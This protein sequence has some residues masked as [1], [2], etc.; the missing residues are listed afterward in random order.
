MAGDHSKQVA[1]DILADRK[2]AD[3]YADPS[4]LADF[5]KGK[6]GASVE[7]AK[8]VAQTILDD[9]RGADYYKDPEIMANYL[10]GAFARTEN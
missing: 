9:R 10:D 6:Y 3:Y 8:R 4:V 7:D 2:G 5:L 1:Q